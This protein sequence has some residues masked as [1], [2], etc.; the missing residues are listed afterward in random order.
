MPDAATYSVVDSLRDGRPI[1]IRALRPEDRDTL[2]AAVRRSSPA[3]MYRRFFSAKREFTED[4][5]SYFLNIDFVKH[6]ALVAEL[7]EAG[8]R[9]II[10]GARYIVVAPGQAEMAFAVVDQYQ[11][12]GVGTV[13]MRNLTKL[14]RDAGLMELSAEVLGDNTSMLKVFEK[15]G[16]PVIRTR[17]AD[18][19]T[20]RMRVSNSA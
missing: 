4:E 18:V 19:V 15:S 10:G 7:D 2:V 11:A 1:L 5:I 3:S 20:I 6:V 17:E 12:L 13:L 16:L 14:A 9:T 8:K